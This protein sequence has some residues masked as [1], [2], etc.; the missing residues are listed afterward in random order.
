MTDLEGVSGV[1]HAEYMDK[2]KPFYQDARRYLMSDVNAA[3]AGAF[4]GGAKNVLVRDAHSSGNNFIM[5]LLDSRAAPVVPKR[6]WFDGLENADAS[7]FVGAHSMAGTYGFL[8]HTQDSTRVFSYKVN[9]KP[10]GEIGQWALG[11]GHFGVPL[12]LVTGD[13][14]ACAEARALL[15]G[16]GTVAVK[17][18]VG[19]NAAECLP[20]SACAEKIRLGAAAALKK[21]FA[22]KPL[23]VK[24]PLLCEQV[25]MRV[26]YA[27]AAA[28]NV[29]RVDPCT[30]C[31]K[32]KRQIDILF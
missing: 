2:S 18:A 10:L 3:V 20:V 30:C 28:K 23:R 4:D 14:H 32:V 8:S 26:D 22:V 15:P 24:K 16:I 13:E 9:G 25:Y 6:S 7:F 11:C 29:E 21:P 5:D 1:G 17:K 31:K 19:R 27:D 12:L